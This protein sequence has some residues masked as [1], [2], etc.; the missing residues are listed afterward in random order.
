VL[1]HLSEALLDQAGPAVRLRLLTARHGTVEHLVELNETLRDGE[2]FQVHQ[3]VLAYDLGPE[4]NALLTP[5]QRRANE[6]LVLDHRVLAIDST[7]SG[8]RIQVELSTPKLAF[9][10]IDLVA[11]LRHD[12]GRF[13]VDSAPPESS[14]ITFQVRPAE[15]YGHIHRPML[16]RISAAVN[17]P[18]QE[19]DLILQVRLDGAAVASTRLRWPSCPIGADAVAPERHTHLGEGRLVAELYPTA[20]RRARLRLRTSTLLPRSVLSAAGKVRRHLRARGSRVSAIVS[21]RR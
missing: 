18:T 4:L 13:I 8:F 14:K 6:D 20:H 2:R 17:S 11:V 1:P 16:T 15:V 21:L 3:G 10:G 19:W 12:Q 5:G 9:D 7:S